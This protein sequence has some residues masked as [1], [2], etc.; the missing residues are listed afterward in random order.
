LAG[1]RYRAAFSKS[2]RRKSPRL[3]AAVFQT[4]PNAAGA[5]NGGKPLTTLDVTRGACP[6]APTHKQTPV[7]SSVNTNPANRRRSFKNV[8]AIIFLPE[9]WYRTFLE[10]LHST[11]DS[12]L[13]L[14]S[15][16]AE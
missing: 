4:D 2:A 14:A 8:V 9:N 11:H 15:A 1:Y 7:R 13:P 10:W 12:R 6:A 3:D 16:F 5:V